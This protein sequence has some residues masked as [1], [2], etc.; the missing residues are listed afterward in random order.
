MW[1]FPWLDIVTSWCTCTCTRV[2]G[3]EYGLAMQEVYTLPRPI[4]GAH[5]GKECVMRVYVWVQCKYKTLVLMAS[6]FGNQT[7]IL[8]L[9]DSSWSQVKS[10]MYKPHSFD[11]LT[12]RSVR[13]RQRR[14][15]YLER[16]MFALRKELLLVP[17]EVLGEDWIAQEELMPCYQEMCVL[18]SSE[19][20]PVR[21]H[22]SLCQVPHKSWQR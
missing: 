9:H 10:D 7:L 16:S 5:K 12:W 19:I 2:S 13:A 17:P 21:V 4:S 1:T 8:M 18:P 22:I 11:N 6:I 3:R 20:L 14:L 15:S